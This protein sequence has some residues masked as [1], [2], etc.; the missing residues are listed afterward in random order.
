MSEPRPTLRL[1][2]TPK[3]GT[4]FERVVEGPEVIV[5]RATAC[6]L[7]LDDR[8]LSRQHTRVKI[9]FK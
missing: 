5:G 1:R 9:D 4:G 6:D 2:A 8:F 7:S 3:R